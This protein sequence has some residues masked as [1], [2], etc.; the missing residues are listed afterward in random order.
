[1]RALF[2]F[3]RPE[4]TTLLCLVALV[5]WLSG[6]GRPPA[7]GG[8]PPDMAMPVVAA[9][10]A[11]EAVEERLPLVG[12]LVAREQVRL[13]SEVDARVESISFEEGEHVDEGTVLVQMDSRRQQARL[14]D[15][16]ARYELARLELQRGR[17]LLERRTIPPQE[18]DRLQAAFLSVEAELAELK[19]DL[20]DTRIAAPFEG[21]ITTRLVSVGQFVSR[22][23]EVAGLILMDPIELEF[24]VPERFANQIERGQQVR[25]RTVAEQNGSFEG[26]V[27]FLAPLIDERSRSLEV[28]ALLDNSEGRLRPGQFGTVDLVFRS[29]D[30]ALLVPETAIRYQGDLVFVTKVDEGRVVSFQPVRTGL[31]LEGRIEILEGLAEGDV[32]VIEGFQKLGPGSKVMFAAGSAEHGVE[33]DAMEPPGEPEPEAAEAADDEAEADA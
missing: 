33:P 12:T 6:C 17:D 32:V 25:M 24:Q 14:A 2:S 11:R 19:A 10:V 3:A 27:F 15:G 4:I 31:K 26:E 8:P 20:E 9:K 13:V 21:V 28:K 18:F 30:D 29:R 22:G 5:P 23:T 7:A 1:M 16:E